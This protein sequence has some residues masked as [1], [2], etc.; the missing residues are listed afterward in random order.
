MPTRISLSLVRAV[1]I[2][3]D[4]QLVTRLASV[5]ILAVGLFWFHRR[6]V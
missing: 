4:G 1:V 3:L 6:V 2:V 5:A